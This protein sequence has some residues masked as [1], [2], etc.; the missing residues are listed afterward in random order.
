MKKLG[1]YIIAAMLLGTTTS[2]NAQIYAIAD[3]VTDLIQPA[4]VGGFNYRGMVEV[5]AIKGIGDNN[6]DFVGISTSQGFKYADWFFMGVGIG[7]DALFTDVDNYYE[8]HVESVTKHGWVIPLFTDFRFT[9]GNTSGINYYIG[10]KIGCSFLVSDRDIQV[11]R[12]YITSDECFYL[13]PAIGVRIP[14]GTT[15]HT[16]VTIA[17]NYQ[18]ITPGYRHYD[19]PDNESISLNGFGLTVG[20]EW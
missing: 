19:F 20:F 6:A 11:N 14:A 7:V 18:L 4:L 17:V 12:G 9:F 3:R 10:T 15:D 2:A 1:K 8:N 13:K 5:S 16:A